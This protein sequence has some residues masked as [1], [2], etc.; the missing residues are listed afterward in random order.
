MLSSDLIKP[1][2]L[3]E[4]QAKTYVAL[5]QLGT[6]SVADIAQKAELKRPT[7]YLCL[8]DLKKLGYVTQS[9]I[10]G[11]LAYSAEPPATLLESL[12]DKQKGLSAILPHLE[13]IYRQKT[14][15]P[16]VKFY[17]GIDEMMKV[18][19]ELY[20]APEIYFWGSVS[21]I[22]KELPVAIS[23]FEHIVKTNKPVV[24]DLLWGDTTDRAYAQRIKKMG[25]PN[26]HIRYLPKGMRFFVDCSIT[27][28]TVQLFSYT[29]E[30]IV[31][32]I[33]SKNFSQ[34]LRTLHQ[35]AWQAAV[36]VLN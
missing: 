18:Y 28:D 17:Q 36:P 4:K 34:S 6:A 14:G 10:H 1:L 21:F 35:L 33:E 23:E 22:K 15:R 30:H 26:Y 7:T 31:V 32:V 3:N 11:A 12:A 9:S 5:L 16:T 27:G 25:N 19:K 8:D 13:S 20:K 29:P 24:Y 2:G